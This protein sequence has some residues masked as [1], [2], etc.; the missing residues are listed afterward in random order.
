MVMSKYTRIGP[1]RKHSLGSRSATALKD[2]PGDRTASA[3]ISRPGLYVLTG[4]LSAAPG[5]AGV[6][7]DADNV[8]LD[9]GG[10]TLTGCEGSLDGI[11]VSTIATNITVRNGDVRGWGQ[12]GVDLSNAIGSCTLNLRVYDN[13]G[14]GLLLGAGARVMNCTMDRNRACGG[15]A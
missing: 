6:R 13:G 1:S 11:T 14:F 3:I 9:L 8:T 12:D 2:L 4:D 10:R 5:K 7:I 15:G